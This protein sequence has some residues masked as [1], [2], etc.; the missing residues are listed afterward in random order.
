MLNKYI[1]EHQLRHTP[2]RYMLLRDIA[3]LKNP[4]TA[5][6]VIA[7]AKQQFISQATV[8]NFL[9]LLI[10]AKMV[11]PLHKQYG[12]HKNDF[13]LVVNGNI[14]MHIIC[15]ECGRVSEFKDVAVENLIKARK[16]SN[17]R[18]EHFSLYVYGKCKLCRR[19]IAKT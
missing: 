18:L 2:E 6:Q 17:F 14:H 1:L 19:K 10:D 8:Y 3:E 5:E 4:F 16:Y 7:K 12:I 9:K 11:H 15:E 13:E